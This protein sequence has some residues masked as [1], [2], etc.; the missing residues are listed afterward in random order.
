MLELCVD[1]MRINIAALKVDYKAYKSGSFKKLNLA[2]LKA[3]SFE[4]RALKDADLRMPLEKAREIA[5]RAFKA[6][7]SE[8]DLDKKV[9]AVKAPLNRFKDF[10][11]TNPEMGDGFISKEAVKLIDARTHEVV[12]PLTKFIMNL[13]FAKAGML[14]DASPKGLDDLFEATA[15][16]ISNVFQRYELYI[17][18][19]LHKNI[20]KPKDV[21]TMALDFAKDEAKAKNTRIEIKGAELLDEFEN[22]LHY[23]YAGKKNR[24]NDCNLFSVFSNLV[25]NAVK[26]SPDNSNVIAKFEKQV[27]DGENF[28]VFSVKDGGIGVPKSE[29]P[30][31]LEGD[32][33]SNAIEAGI[34]GTGYGLRTVYSALRDSMGRLNINSPLH[35]ENAKFPGS[36]FKCFIRCEQK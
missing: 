5:V 14:K 1:K 22:G 33:G 20:T 13:E 30:N 9:E 3:D 2:P 6:L 28:L 24:M 23:T 12:N 36:E 34:E 7:K 10:I 18:K 8:T 4:I 15:K 26:Y 11:Y 21:F 31:L 32:R 29:I 19:G 27:V 17:D 35:P 16:R 25:H